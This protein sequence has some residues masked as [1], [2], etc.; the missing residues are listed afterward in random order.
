MAGILVATGFVRIDADTNPA[1]K[2]L[3]A[4][5][6]IGASA[7]TTT[8][9]PVTAVVTAGVAAMGAS[10]AAA[11]AA[12]GAFG[13]AVGPQFAKVTE[14][15]GAYTK[16]QDAQQKAELLTAQAHKLA[17]KGG[18]EYK[19][20]LQKAKTATDAAREADAMYQ[21]KLAEMTPATRETAKAFVRLKEDFGKWSDS[22]SGDTM[23]IFTRGINALRDALPKLTPFVRMASTQIKDFVDSLGEGQAGKVF[24]EFGRNLRRNAGGALKSLLGTFKN[25]AVGIVGILNAFMPMSSQVGGGLESLTAKFAAFG[26]GLGKSQ[27]FAT[28]MKTVQDGAPVLRQTLGEVAA[29]FGKIA[30]AA[31]PLAGVGIQVLRVFSA[32]IAAI[33]TP[34]LKAL[35]PTILAVNV[36]LKLYALYTAAATAATWAFGSATGASRASMLALRIG[37]AAYWVQMRL[38]S[39]WTAITTSATWAWT[40]A[41]LANPIT[42]IVVAIAALVAAIVLIATKTTWFQT[43]WKYSWNAIKAAFS[44]V[45]D[46]IKKH[47]MWM[48]GAMFGP[49]GIFVVAVIKNWGSIRKAFLDAWGAINRTVVQPFVRFFTQTI[50]DAAGRARARIV[51]EWDA[52]YKRVSGAWNSIKRTAID[53]LVRFFTKTIPDAARTT[54]DRVI[55]Y[56]NNI[57]D[58]I[59]SAYAAFKKYALDPINRFFSKT[60][61]N[62]A[63][64][65]RDGMLKPIRFMVNGV[66]SGFGLIIKGAAKLFG[67]VPGIGGK[68]KAA[69]RKFEQFQR[70]VNKAL[71]GIK[72]KNQTTFVTFKGKS[73]AAV[74]AGR[75][76]T[77]G[78]IRGPGTPTS[79]SVPILASDDEHMWTSKEV[80]GAG[81]HGNIYRLRALARMRKLPRFA[82]GGGV[83]PKAQVPS[84]QAINS[85]ANVAYLNMVKSSSKALAKMRDD[86]EAAYGGNLN[87]GG[88]G[89]K[90]WTGAVK[91]ALSAV[92]QS[93]AYVGITLRRMNQESGGNPRVVNKWDSNWKAGY[94]SVGLMQVIRPTFQSNAGKYR[95]TGP[96]LYGVSIAP[97]ANLYASMRYALRAYGSLPR[98]YNR[99]GGYG[100]GTAG[101]AGGMH[102]FGE[103][104]PEMG[105]SPAG[106]RVLNHRQTA[107]IGGAGAGLV[108]ERLV[109]ENHGVISS[110]H[111]VENWLVDSLDQLRRKGR[112]K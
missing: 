56:W 63:R 107:R 23:P 73:I 10:I 41:L 105:F 33:P 96:F 19:A 65:A 69:S 6:S 72:N 87:V 7:L 4:L 92:G 75:M 68:L 60:I 14:A 77:G 48:L 35:V 44:F 45:V 95:R 71:G 112:I 64:D 54:K 55:G 57:R 90:R 85:T 22:L 50:P 94:P 31:G 21:A 91:Q 18:D 1:K 80:R 79:D 89:V 30:S 93:Q 17:A 61:P 82:T 9:L 98:A 101:T 104:G 43:A 76:A 111:E 36:G 47:W 100:N 49:L 37:M 20:A 52:I 78:P 102:L 86:M 110:Q 34:V 106:W 28:F 59:N 84:A 12:A 27:G 97:I 2:A 109:L 81:G 15:S 24:S 66:L 46:F 8:L 16:S 108:I 11:G 88:A 51:A 74:S 83:N 29:A 32:L 53:P 38:I 3:M 62:A 70:D 26:A 58:K 39:I 13:A 103:H 40:A 5:G 42:W 99:K 67:W 25:I